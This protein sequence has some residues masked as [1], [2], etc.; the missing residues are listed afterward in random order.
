MNK[1]EI[2][3]AKASSPV[4]ITRLL[5]QWDTC[6]LALDQVKYLLEEDDDT[7]ARLA[8]V[9]KD[10]GTQKSFEDTLF[11]EVCGDSDF[12]DREYEDLC[13]YLTETLKAMSPDGYFK[14]EVNNFGWRNQSGHKYIQ[15]DGGRELLQKI[16]PDTECTFKIFKVKHGKMLAI[17]NF[18][19][20]SPVEAEW[21]VVKPC[22]ASTY[23]ANK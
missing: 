9:I 13:D 5:T 4:A 11:N 18:H 21:Y 22:A 17:Q 7:K 2:L 10:G 23:H 12:Y 19:H 20:D 8:A 16:L 14:A 6:D 1:Q 3:R 15:A